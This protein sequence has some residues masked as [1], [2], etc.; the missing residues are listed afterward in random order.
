MADNIETPVPDGLKIATDEVTNS[1]D[2]S[3]AQFVKIM[4]GAGGSAQP[5][6][7]E[8]NGALRSPLSVIQILGLP[9]ISSGSGYTAGDVVGTPVDLGVYPAGALRCMRLVITSFAGLT[10]PDLDVF[11]VQVSS[12]ETPGDVGVDGDPFVPDLAVAAN[13]L[14]SNA[15][16]FSPLD[17]D[18]KF[19]EWRTTQMHLLGDAVGAA[20][21]WVLVIRAGETFGDDLTGGVAVFGQAEYVVPNAIDALT[22]S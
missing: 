2:T 5:L 9:T 15:A 1:G 13:T 7:V 4:S 12:T 20:P 8:S 21:R 16:G 17:V 6:V 18:P 10:L 22:P 3:H 11:V 14:G 19:L